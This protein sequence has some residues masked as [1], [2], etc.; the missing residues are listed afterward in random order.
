[1]NSD[2]ATVAVIEAIEA[3]QI[4][5]MLV[6]SLSSNYYGVSRSTKD[7]DFVI[8]LG[9]KRITSVMETLPSAF[10]LNP[11]I[12]FET[13]PGTVRYIIDVNEIPFRIEMFRLGDDPHDQERFA[14]R[15]RVFVP[16]FQRQAFIPR[17]ED[18]IV[19]KLRWQRGK[20][21]DDVRDM[22]AVQA[23]AIDWEYVHRWSDLHGTRELLD[24]IRSSIPPI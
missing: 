9:D 23:D 5:Y 21:R 15:S 1:M 14:R 2:E 13:I 19:T 12:T 6:G 8:E 24:E 7:A 18:V 10:R 20:D 22:I 16:Q 17:V 11:Q 3:S 4:S